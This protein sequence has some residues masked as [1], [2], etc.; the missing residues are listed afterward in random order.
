MVDKIELEVVLGA[1]KITFSPAPRQH[2][3][4]YLF[5][6]R[7]RRENVDGAWQAVERMAKGLAKKS[8]AKRRDEMPLS[9]LENEKNEV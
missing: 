6:R 8:G 9:S 5:P 4:H 3:P 1:T 2:A 7:G